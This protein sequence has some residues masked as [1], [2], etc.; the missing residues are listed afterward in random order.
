MNNLAINLPTGSFLS[1]VDRLSSR[2]GLINSAVN[3]LVDRIAPIK[4][5][6]A[7][8]EYCT[9]YCQ[10]TDACCQ[11]GVGQRRQLMRTVPL[12]GHTCNEPEYLAVCTGPC[13]S[14]CSLCGGC[15]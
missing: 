9:Q 4:L 6:L 10:W 7:C 15:F 3:L 1:T 11:C 2:I 12:S 13:S 5:A 8:H 14:S